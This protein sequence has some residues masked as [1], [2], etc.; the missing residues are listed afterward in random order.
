MLCEAPLANPFEPSLLD[1]KVSWQAA[2][3]WPHKSLA[4]A[5]FGGELAAEGPPEVDGRFGVAVAH[6]EGL[7]VLGVWSVP[8]AGSRYGDEVL[9]VIDSCAD[10]IGGGDVIVAG[11][12]NI[13]AKGVANG[14]RG[15]ELF[16]SLVA[17]LSEL[18]LVSAYHAWTG[19]A[20]GAE[21]RMT[22]FHLRKADHGF[23]ID[24]CFIP[25]GWNSRVREVAVGDPAEW[26]PFS[27]HMPIVVDIDR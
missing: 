5:A 3:P 7:G 11:D 25:S 18:G 4:V 10:W 24:Y 27:D 6:D 9:N 12:F 1:P 20:F 13:D 16:A 15:A 22:H 19:E 23:H 17:R 2:G 8:A 26:L 21:S 14:T